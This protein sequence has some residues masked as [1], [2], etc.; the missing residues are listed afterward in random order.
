VIAPVTFRPL[1]WHGPTTP[2]DRRRLAP[3]RAGFRQTL[4]LLDAELWQ[5]DARDVVVEL[6]IGEHDLRR[7]GWPRAGARPT[8]PGVRLAFGS[9]HGPLVYA[10][11]SCVMWQDN[12]RSI[13]LGLEA[14]RAVDR[15][16]VTRRGEQY[17]GWAAIEV[18]PADMGPEAAARIVAKL[19]GLAEAV[20]GEIVAAPSRYVRQAARNAHPDTGGS[21]ELWLELQAAARALGAPL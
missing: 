15:Y 16:G 17:R 1:Q 4:D 8:F 3:F 9:R 21:R 13:A 12:L 19:A 5:L 11:D 10:T 7:D 18:R 2:D 6:A 14:L 20:C